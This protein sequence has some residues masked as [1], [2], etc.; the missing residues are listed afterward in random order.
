MPKKAVIPLKIA[1]L[2]RVIAQEITDPA[3]RAA[4]DRARKQY[5]RKWAAQEKKR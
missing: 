1:R 5:K 3:E 2:Q 4:I